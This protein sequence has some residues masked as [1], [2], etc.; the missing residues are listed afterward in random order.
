MAGSTPAAY[1][2]GVGKG[3]KFLLGY[4]NLVASKSN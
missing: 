3:A 1:N 4:Q 2:L